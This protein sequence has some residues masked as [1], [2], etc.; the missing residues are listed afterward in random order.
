MATA[1]PSEESPLLNHQSSTNDNGDQN[2]PV[3]SGDEVAV[4]DEPTNAYLQ[5]SLIGIYLSAFVAAIDSSMIATLSA[6]ISETFG[7]LSRLSWLASAFFIATAAVQPLSGK[8]TD[9]YGRRNGA[10]VTNV[11]FALGNSICALSQSEWTLICGRLVAG[12][13]GGGLMAITTF[14]L[15]DC[16]LSK[17]IFYFG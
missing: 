14:V 2:N 12:V 6:P 8:L 9:I 11:I 10:V 16:K 3:A 4:V 1:I 7:S 5:K 13:G 17:A 15:S